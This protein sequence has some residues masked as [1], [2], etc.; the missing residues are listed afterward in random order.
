MYVLYTAVSNQSWPHALFFSFLSHLHRS[1][2][3]PCIDLILSNGRAPIIFSS[4]NVW[5][6]DFEE[7]ISLL[8]YEIAWLLVFFIISLKAFNPHFYIVSFVT[9]RISNKADKTFVCLSCI[10]WVF[11][12]ILGVCSCQIKLGRI[13]T[14][15]KGHSIKNLML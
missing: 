13:C 9:N 1:T 11:D 2:V 4:R 5:I 12:T 6:S 3:V 10:I 7:Y 8:R 14:Q 15:E